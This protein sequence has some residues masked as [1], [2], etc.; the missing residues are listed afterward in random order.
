VVGACQEAVVAAGRRQSPEVIQVLGEHLERLRAVLGSLVTPPEPH[1]VPVPV[2][3]AT[4]RPVRR[5]RD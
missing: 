1:P 2:R 3:V 4:P 5:P